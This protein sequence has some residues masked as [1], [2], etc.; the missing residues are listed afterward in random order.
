MRDEEK[1]GWAEIARRLG[2]GRTPS[3]CQNVGMILT[4]LLKRHARTILT[5]GNAAY[6]SD[7][8][9]LSSLE[10]ENEYSTLLPTGDFLNQET[11]MVLQVWRQELVTSIKSHYSILTSELSRNFRLNQ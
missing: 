2:N 8:K 5:Q 3:A 11:V 9:P 4:G 7:L 1:M 6:H 10:K